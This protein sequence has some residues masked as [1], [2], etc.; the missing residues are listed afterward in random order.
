MATCA[1]ASHITKQMAQQKKM[2]AGCA[3]CDNLPP[4]QAFS[5]ERYVSTLTVS[6]PSSSS[7]LF[8]FQNSNL[9]PQPPTPG[10]SYQSSAPYGP[11]TPAEPSAAELL[12]A[13]VPAS[14]PS[15]AADPCNLYASDY[16][17]ETISFTPPLIPTSALP[18]LVS[19]TKISCCHFS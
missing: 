15:G 1:N 18:G 19:Q 3:A 14:S 4:A 10:S 17:D 13:D 16:G 2:R 12:P 9:P 11:A 7:S 6:S 8:G 5:E